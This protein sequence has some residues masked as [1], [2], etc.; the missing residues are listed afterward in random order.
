VI[1]AQI[2]SPVSLMHTSALFYL[3]LIL[4]ILG[5]LTNLT[6]QWISRRFGS[7]MS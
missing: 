7:R 6:A 1:A 2:G 3:A 4:L 5:M